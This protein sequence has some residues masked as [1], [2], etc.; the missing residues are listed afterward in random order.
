MNPKCECGCGS[1]VAIRNGKASRFVHGHNRRG[2]PATHLYADLDE[3]YVVD[4]STGCWNWTS[5]VNHK[6]YGYCQY[7]GVGMN[8]HRAY[9]IYSG[10]TIPDGYHLDHLCYNRL[11]VNPDHMEPVTPTE[12]NHRRRDW[13]AA[14]AYEEATGK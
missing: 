11:C 5:H 8:A 10:R 2:I 14:H 9:W 7:K 4:P 12:N 3:K 6:G 13:I 1:A